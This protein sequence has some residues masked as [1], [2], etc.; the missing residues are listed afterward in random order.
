[1]LAL[2]TASASAASASSQA[3]AVSPFLLG[4]VQRIVGALQQFGLG[5]GIG[6]PLHQPGAEG[7]AQA[8][9]SGPFTSC[10]KLREQ[11]LAGGKRL[12]QRGVAEQQGKLLATQAR[13]QI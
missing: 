12:L 3:D 13:G 1:Q 2:D 7:D 6:P 10:M 8:I 5:F 11:A 4:P 9:D